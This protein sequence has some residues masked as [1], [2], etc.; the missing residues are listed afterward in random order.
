MSSGI[1]LK[2]EKAKLT[3]EEADSV[4]YLMNLWG[5]EDRDN[6]SI[7]DRSISILVTEKIDEDWGDIEQAIPA[8]ELPHGKFIR[9]ITVGFEVEQTPEEK[10]LELHD[11]YFKSTTMGSMDARFFAGKVAGIRE[12]LS[13]L[14]FVIEGINKSEEEN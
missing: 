1:S 2:T 4:R 10:L 6:K 7:D 5:L 13:T 8:K 12:T 3:K 9:A 11:H 14:G